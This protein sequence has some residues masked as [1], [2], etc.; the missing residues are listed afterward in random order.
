MWSSFGWLKRKDKV[1]KKII[2]C[3]SFLTTEIHKT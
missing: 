1:R 3:S 2:Q